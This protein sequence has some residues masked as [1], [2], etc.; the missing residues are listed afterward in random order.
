[1][2]PELPLLLWLGS[3]HWVLQ[4]ISGL[5]QGVSGPLQRTQVLLPDQ[6]TL[7]SVLLAWIGVGKLLEQIQYQ[8]L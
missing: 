2:C 5:F 7:V 3:F 6:A 1:M 4:G 8:G